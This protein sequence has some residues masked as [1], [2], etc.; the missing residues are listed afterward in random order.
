MSVYRCKVRLVLK[1]MKIAFFLQ[2]CLCSMKAYI[3]QKLKLLKPHI[4]KPILK[5]VKLSYDLEKPL[6]TMRIF[7]LLQPLNLIFDLVPWV[8]QPV[9]ALFPRPHLGDLYKY[10][11]PT[12]GHLQPAF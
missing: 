10:A 3:K 2:Y 8:D 11:G 1:L 7:F 12:M 9:F 4:L 5:C 6:K